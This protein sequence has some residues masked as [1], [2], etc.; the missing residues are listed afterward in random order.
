[1]Q[2]LANYTEVG[3]DPEDASEDE[4]APM[5]ASVSGEQVADAHDTD[6]GTGRETGTDGLTEAEAPPKE[7]PPGR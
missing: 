7:P 3:E 1:M 6:R 4:A 5:P 2:H